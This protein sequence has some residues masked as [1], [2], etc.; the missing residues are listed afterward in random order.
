MKT[1]MILFSFFLIQS[2]YSF[3][4]ED[5]VD[6]LPD[7]S[8]NGTLYSGYLNVSDV[9]KFHYMFNIPKENP[10]SKPLVL[11]LNGGPGCSSLDGWANEHG[12]MLLD[13]KGQFQLNNY[14]WVNEA[15]MIYLESPGNV[16]FSFINSTSEEDLFADDNTTAKE[17]FQA[18]LSFFDKFPEMKNKDFYISGES[19][20]GI[21][22]PM[23]AYNIIEY[24]EGIEEEGKK[25][26][27]KG[28]LVGNG[29]TDWKYD[30]TFAMM[31][32][33]FTHHLTSYEHRLD[34]VKY[35]LTNATYDEE[36]CNEAYNLAFEIIEGINYYDYLRECK[37]PKNLKGEISTK[38]KYYRYA[39]WAFERQKT[40]DEEIL[41]LSEEDDGGQTT[42]CFD[43]TNVEN[44][45]SR[46]DVQNALHVINLTKWKVCSDSIFNNYNRSDAGS[47]WTYPK[48]IEANLSILIYSG[49][50]DAIVPFNGN[51]LWIRDL[52]LE[53]E[54]PWR[55]WRVDNDLNNIAGYV[56]K[57]KGLTFCT[58]KGTG[59]M[60]PG[61]KPKE[62][63][64]MFSKFLKGEDF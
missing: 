22:V 37:V 26:K 55:K 11:W 21:Y 17:N 14:T 39:P 8:Y 2:I 40:T 13:E 9:K 49:D 30:S 1:L 51:L 20:G 38:S 48:L 5:K 12:P 33:L 60:A 15:N 4:E 63:F 6:S 31:D 56:V 32:F 29:V 35:C 18:L 47:I 54:E 42:A 36:K 43:D 52:K 62:S 25:I 53:T 28:I 61:W 23:L 44:Y 27:L 3:P 57:Y 59:H 10:D 41:N 16:G 46:A 50:T 19:Y 64:Y 24:N 7:Y 58:I 34:Y 45:F